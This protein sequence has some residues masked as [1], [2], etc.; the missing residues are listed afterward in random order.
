MQ[1]NAGN[2]LVE[3]LASS[4]GAA[5]VVAITTFTSEKKWNEVERLQVH[6]Q[7]MQT[8]HGYHLR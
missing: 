6:R 3:I 7:R 2:P 4:V 8:P 5:S 1:C